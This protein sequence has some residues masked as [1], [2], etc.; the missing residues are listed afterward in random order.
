MQ[1]EL[2]HA[3]AAPAVRIDEVKQLVDVLLAAGTRLTAAEICGRM[4]G[5]ATETLKRRV[6]A[7]A[8]VA[9]PRVV[10][11]PGS[12]GYELWERCTVDEILHG[13][14]ALESQG[15]DM[16]KDANLYRM[17]YHRRLRRATAGA[18]DNGQ[19]SLL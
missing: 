4:F 6:R 18:T 12:A 1:T 3:S 17:A 11:F 13:I 10:S 15:K 14:E 16:I 5:T 9:R 19:L 8:K 7:I 2:H